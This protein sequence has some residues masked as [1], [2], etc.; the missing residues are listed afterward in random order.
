MRFYE[1]WNLHFEDVV[2]IL[3]DM[4]RATVAGLV[5]A[6]WSLVANHDV[7]PI[8][9]FLSSVT[10]D[11]HKD[12]KAFELRCSIDFLQKFVATRQFQKVNNLIKAGET[13]KNTKHIRA[14]QLLKI[15]R[16]CKILIDNKALRQ[17]FADRIINFAVQQNIDP[18]DFSLTR[19]QEQTTRRDQSFGEPLSLKFT[20]Q[21]KK[22]GFDVFKINLHQN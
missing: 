1:N 20:N 6:P 18:F 14:R 7:A 13:R 3:I 15:G 21:F 17:Q 10:Y 12:A 11:W 4:F 16:L 2:I 5:S 19:Q 8:D 22:Y 9:K